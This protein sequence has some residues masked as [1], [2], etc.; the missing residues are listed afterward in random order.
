M[1]RRFTRE[2]LLIAGEPEIVDCLL[3]AVRGAALYR[4]KKKDC[5]MSSAHRGNLMHHLS[6]AYHLLLAKGVDVTA[7]PKRGTS[8][9]RVR[10]E[11]AEHIQQRIVDRL[12][13]M[14]RR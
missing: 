6:K 10:Q 13:E 1:T 3:Q 5:P 2:E 9:D 8:G 4:S 14:N 7:I 11:V 12:L